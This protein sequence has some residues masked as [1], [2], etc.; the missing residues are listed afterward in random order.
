MINNHAKSSCSN[1][2]PVVAEKF[3]ACMGTHGN[4]TGVILTNAHTSLLSTLIS[5]LL[6]KVAPH[7]DPN[8]DT[9][10]FKSKRGKKKDSENSNIAKKAKIDA[11]P[12]N[13]LTWPELARRYVLA[14]LSMEGNLDCTEIISRESG[15]VFHCLQGDGGPLCGSLTG[16]AAMEAD[17]LVRSKSHFLAETYD[18]ISCLSC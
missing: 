11:L 18:I 2:F 15:R 6:I 8:F 14:V 13:D 16:V 3:L 1:Y 9:G 7:V 12:I 10:E 5:E 17:A 4:C